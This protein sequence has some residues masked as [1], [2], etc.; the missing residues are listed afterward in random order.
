LA[1]LASQ[2]AWDAAKRVEHLA[3]GGDFTAL[4]V[5]SEALDQELAEL[6]RILEAFTAQPRLARPA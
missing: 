5:A 3:P 2:R 4:Q 6:I 1:V